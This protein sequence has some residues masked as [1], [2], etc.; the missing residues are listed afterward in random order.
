[1][2]YLLIVL[3]LFIGC[4]DDPVSPEPVYGC[5]VPSACNFNPNATIFDDSCIYGEL[6]ICNECGESYNCFYGNWYYESQSY[7]VINFDNQDCII[8]QKLDY[9]IFGDIDIYSDGTLGWSYICDELWN[10]EFDEF[11]QSGEEN[12]I[13]LECGDNGFT[14]EIQYDNI[15]SQ[16]I[17]DGGQVQTNE[18]GNEVCSSIHEIIYVKAE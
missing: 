11:W 1:M 12:E 3:L 16:L 8:G 6:N 5:T 7:E 14:T 9:Q 15:N 18:F 2:R 17:I 4:D 10:W 13:R